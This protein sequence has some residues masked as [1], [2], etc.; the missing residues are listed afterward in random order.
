MLAFLAPLSL[1]KKGVLSWQPDG[2]MPGT[3]ALQ[4]SP[5][6]SLFPPRALVFVEVAHD[7]YSVGSIARHDLSPAGSAAKKQRA[8][9]S[10]PQHKRELMRQPG[11]IAGLACVKRPAESC[12]SRPAAFRV[13]TPPPV[14]E[15]PI[16]HHTFSFMTYTPM[17]GTPPHLRWRHDLRRSCLRHDRGRRGARSC[18]M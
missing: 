18:G 16:P 5:A 14:D 13:A 8:R 2:R 3:R 6:R 12:P 1:S 17:A 9:A 10:Q 11:A 7:G 4:P 15:Q